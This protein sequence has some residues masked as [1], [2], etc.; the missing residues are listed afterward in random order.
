[1]SSINDFIGPN[2]EVRYIGTY[3]V[4]TVTSGPNNSDY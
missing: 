3:D 4:K 2:E 1:M